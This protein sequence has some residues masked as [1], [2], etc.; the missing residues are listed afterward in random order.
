MKVLKITLIVVGCLVALLFIIIGVWL[1]LH[2]Q[3]VME[4][5]QVNS[6]TM[7]RRVL[8]AAQ[9]SDFK[10]ALVD[11]LVTHLRGKSVYISVVDVT[12]LATVDEEEW[13]AL[14]IIHTVE[15]WKLQSDVNAYLDRAEDLDKVLLI[16]TSGSGQWRTE[17][18]DVD[19]ITS[20]SKRDELHALVPDILKWLDELLEEE[21]VDSIPEHE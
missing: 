21:M 7:E 19:V 9:G 13:D 12:T 10:E 1:L 14:V 3:G 18:Y 20:A 11:S 4:P 8:I 2:R 15:Q 16:T 5:F 6:P 17:E